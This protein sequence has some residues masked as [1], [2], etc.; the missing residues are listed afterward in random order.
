L[1]EKLIIKN[2]GPIKDVELE[3]GRLTVLI[4]EQATGKSTIAKL[5][6]VCRYFSYIVEDGSFLETGNQNKFLEGL[7]AWG[8]DEALSPESYIHYTCSHYALTVEW[9]D[10]NMSHFDIETS[11]YAESFP[12]FICKLIPNSDK[13]KNL[14]AELDKI[15]PKDHKEM[16][17]WRIPTSFFINDVS[18]VMDNPFF[19][20]T[21]R[22]LQSIFSLGYAPNISNT[23]F[24]QLAKLDDIGRLFVKDTLIEPLNIIYK[25]LPTGHNLIKKS[26]GNNYFSLHKGASGYQS[27]IPII[28]SVKYYND[29]K[30]KT[31]TFIIEEPELNLFPATQNKLVEYLVDK[32]MNYG[33]G[34][35]LTTHSPYILTSLNNLLYAYKIGQIDDSATVNLIPKKY[36]LNSDDVSVYMMLPNGEYEDI[37]DR[38]ESMIFA[39]KID[40]VSRILN[41]QFDSLLNIE[42]P[43]NELNT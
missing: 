4:G 15:K 9:V 29:I 7:S 35:L 30:K 14:L 12:V 2:F 13:F 10:S 19:L 41:E 33:N 16:L 28:L 22:G 17:S 11:T 27:A 31:K 36:W 1:K 34:L 8:L 18:A 21:E 3:L 24:N 26:E 6:A 32:T 37:F 40:G 23:L 39:E 38:K 42:F 43:E 25:N 5:L 20:P